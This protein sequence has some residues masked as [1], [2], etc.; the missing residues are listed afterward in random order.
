LFWMTPLALC[1]LFYL[2]IPD[3]RMNATANAYLFGVVLIYVQTN[4]NPFLNN[5]IGL[6]F[7][8]VALFSLRTLSRAGNESP[9]RERSLQPSA[10]TELSSIFNQRDRHADQGSED[11]AEA[12]HQGLARPG[13]SISV[14]R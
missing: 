5:P 13:G 9:P 1:V 2:R 3:R 4:M 12:N 14:G 11:E 10:R 7:V 6:S 8:L